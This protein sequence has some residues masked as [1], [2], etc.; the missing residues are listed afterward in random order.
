[1]NTEVFQV[2]AQNSRTRLDVFLAARLAPELSRSQLSRMIRAGLVSING[3]LARP[4]SAIR[5][6]DLVEVR[7]PIPTVRGP[8]QHQET[9]HV[10]VP[11][12][13]DDEELI[14]VNKPHGLTVHG[15]SGYPHPTLVG[16]LLSQFPELAVMN[17]PDGVMRPGIVHRLDKD[18]SGVMVVARTP[19]ARNALSRQFKNRTVRK[20][21]LAVVRGHVGRDRF[22]ISRAIG[23]H[24]V[25][26]KRMSVRS[27][28]SRA[29]VTHIGVLRRFEIPDDQGF[30]KLTLVI[31][32]PETG[33]THQIRVHLSSIGHPCVGDQ[34]YGSGRKND[35]HHASAQ[36]RRQALHALALE[37]D[38]PRGGTR[39]KF[40]APP[41]EDMTELLRPADIE[42][43]SGDLEK[44]TSESIA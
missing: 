8:V 7:Q 15:F 19:F 24:P 11:V 28:T 41:A 37:L 1:L 22:T 21:Y 5:A 2:E 38:H 3:T 13:Y 25:E 16:S 33:R 35:S 4:S 34:L 30:E 31:A 10:R 27:R 18:T 36:I 17:E 6:G 32:R 9:A 40:L 44:W 39:M 29:A 12:L 14:E 20:T 42:L 43:T 23:R 26:R